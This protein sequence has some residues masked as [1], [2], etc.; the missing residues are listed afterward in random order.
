MNMVFFMALNE[1]CIDKAF[2]NKVFLCLSTIEW[3]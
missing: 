3:E 1:R 2:I